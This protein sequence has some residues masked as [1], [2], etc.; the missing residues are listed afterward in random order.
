MYL[1]N[2]IKICIQLINTQ[3]TFHYVSIKSQCGT[4]GEFLR[5]HLHSTMYLLNRVLF[6]PYDM[7]FHN[8]H[9]TMYL[10]NLN[11]FLNF[12]NPVVNLHSTM[13]LLNLLYCS[14]VISSLSHLHSTMYLLNPVPQ[15]LIISQAYFVLFCRPT[16]IHGNKICIHQKLSLFTA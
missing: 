1:L 15:H 4:A 2:L 3:F 12:N 13:Y 11:T 9:S 16:I 5:V 7:L 14:S 8:L 10:L 6:L